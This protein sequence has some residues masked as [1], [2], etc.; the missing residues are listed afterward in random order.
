MFE[1]PSDLSFHRRGYEWAIGCGPSQFLIAEGPASTLQFG[2]KLF[3]DLRWP[4]GIDVLTIARWHK[5]SKQV[6]LR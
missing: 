1:T 5:V 3:A 4:D 6:G 2:K